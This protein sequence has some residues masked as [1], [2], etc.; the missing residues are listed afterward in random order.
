[1]LL[2]LFQSLA[3]RRGVLLLL[4]ALSWLWAAPAWAVEIRV[5]IQQGVRS[6]R[7]GASTQA[8]VTDGSGR[9][10]GQLAPLQAF[11][12]Q[13]SSPGISVGPFRAS[14]L[15][16]E[17]S[18]GGFVFIGNDWYR[19]RVRLL[20]RG[21]G[22]LAVNHIDLEEYLYSVVGS[23]MFPDWPLEAL[24]AQ[25]VA[26]RS[27]VLYRR[28]RPADPQFDVGRTVT[29]QAYKGLEREASST[30]EAVQATAGQILVHQGRVIEAVYHASSGGHTENSEDVWMRPLPYLRGVPDFDQQAPVF[31]WTKMVSQAE[32]QR[33][34]PGLGRILNLTAVRRTPQGRI[35]A[36]RLVGERGSR[37]VEGQELRQLFDLRSTRF[38]VT[39]TPNQIAST[40]VTS[41]IPSAFEFSG[42]GFGHGLGM[43]QWGAYG[44]ALQGHTYP[45]I[46]SHYYRGTALTA[47][48]P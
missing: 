20:P 42:Q 14:Q 34:F 41:T 11:N 19:G 16:V 28:Q 30:R 48:R 43:S 7:V 15:W 13:P 18:D 4:I 32:M 26:A 5:A 9:P 31:Q 44:M 27:F 45:A 21:D 36:M 23:E 25:A 1:M 46:L 47:L 3:R 29:W 35:V 10:L 12:A 37:T 33:R 6:L 2:R 22:L 24:K 8:R 38:S 40:V 39:P 17:P